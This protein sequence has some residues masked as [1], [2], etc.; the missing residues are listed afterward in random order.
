M[1]RPAQELKAFAKVQLAAGESKTV[2]LTLDDKA[3]RYWNTKTD[4]W[5]VEGGSYEIR[6]GASSAD[7][8]LTAVVEVA[9]TEAPNPYAGKSLPH[10]E[11]GKVQSVPDAEWETLMGCLIPE[12]K[13]RI[14]RN[15]TLGELNHSRGP[16]CW[17][18]W[19]VLG[20]MTGITQG[21]S[22]LVAQFYGA[23]EKENLKC[24]VAKSYIMTALLS[25][26]VLAVSEG[27]VYHVLLFLQTPDNVIDL[28][29]LYLRLIFAGIPIIAA[30]NIFAA[31][32]RALGNSR[33]PLIAMTVAAL[34]N[35]GL[36]LLFVAVF[37]WGVAGAAVATVIAQ[38]VSAL[39]CLMVLRKIPDIR[40]EKQDFYR[41][42][43]M[44]LRLLKVATPL[45]IQNVI[46]SVGGLTVQYV[47]N[48]FGFLFV[49]GF[50]ASNK[51]Y[52][53]LEMAAVSYGYA[54]TTY[55]GQ[56][57]GAKKYQRI[58]KGVHSGTY[59]ALL[60]SVVISG[61]MVLF[62][63]NILSLFVSGEPEQ[64]RQVLDIAYKYLFIMAIFLWVLYLLYVY[65]SA[66]QGLGNTLIPLASGIAEFV[67]RVSVALL[68]PKLIGE[69][70]IFY[71]E[72]CAWT[73]AAVLLFISYMIIIRK[74]KDSS[75]LPAKGL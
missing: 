47:V 67:M 75:E 12:D 68:L 73:S 54:I 3:F 70:G 19:L 36:D 64:I 38:G 8:R 72:I 34:I 65:R 23:R 5:E 29:M 69:D 62:G 35:V 11:S 48:G 55:V 25:V 44:S 50:T 40:L 63:R 39:Y 42:P 31:I 7:I 20:I 43:A 27:A 18:V 14:D 6:V 51:L 57:L 24:A 60:T 33:S 16:I 66:I 4:S 74:Y 10:Y 49:A 1:F 13:V 46:I 52:G 71:A 17:L 41:Q 30:Y 15:M 61:V 56:N 32:L 58:R 45:A 22:I 21:F 2:T 26:I 37:G 59:M 9:G 28:T 53:V